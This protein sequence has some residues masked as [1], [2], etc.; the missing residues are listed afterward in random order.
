MLKEKKKMAQLAKR[1]ILP[2][3]ILFTFT[4]LIAGERPGLAFLNTEMS[5][6][7][8][9]LAGAMVAKRGEVH[10][11]FHNPASLSGIV[12]TT[13]SANFVNHL[14]DIGGGNLMMA[15]KI[16]SGNIGFGL[17]SIDYG[18]FNR[19]DDR[20][21]DLGTDFSAS[22]LL[23]SVSYSLE[24]SDAISLGSN[25]KWA[26]SNIDEYSSNAIALDVGFL[27]FQP[28]RDLSIGGGIFSLGKSTAFIDNSDPLPTNFRLGISK[29]LAHLPLRVNAE[30]IWLTYGKWKALASGEI[31]LSPNVSLI[32]GLNSNRLDLDTSSLSVDFYSGGNI[33]L[34]VTVEKWRIDYALSSY[35]GAGLIQRFG[36]SG[37]F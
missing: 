12:G 20:G 30:G 6:R 11:V 13:W 25:I 22:D 31:I 16:E 33:G 2:I 15:K 29:L 9:S 24:I 4:N 26:N 34:G 27:Y 32:L 5:A 36:L 21:N 8:A 7:G 19:L 17:A 37:N 18:S 3:T 28:E 14:L 23:V 10:G 1:F 35:G